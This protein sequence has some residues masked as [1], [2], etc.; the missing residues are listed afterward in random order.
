LAMA[1][2]IL[3]MKAGQFSAAYQGGE[4]SQEQLLL[5]AS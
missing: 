3:V 2:R 4:A 5:A 1:D